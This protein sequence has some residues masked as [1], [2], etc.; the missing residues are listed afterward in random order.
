MSLKILAGFAA[1]IIVGVTGI[2]YFNKHSQEIETCV[3]GSKFGKWVENRLPDEYAS[4]EEL[5]SR[6]EH[7]EDLISELQS[8][9]KTAKAPSAK[10]KSA[11]N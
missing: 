9:Q 11:K 10:A 2:R 8:A 5:E 7:L 1:G 3:K 4:L 6:K